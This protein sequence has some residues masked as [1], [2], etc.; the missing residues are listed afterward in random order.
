MVFVPVLL[1]QQPLLLLETTAVAAAALAAAEKFATVH[2]YTA[3]GG[4]LP[5]G[6]PPR[7]LWLHV[8]QLFPCC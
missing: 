4:A 6:A 2:K 7:F 8:L 3:G 1:Q 5:L